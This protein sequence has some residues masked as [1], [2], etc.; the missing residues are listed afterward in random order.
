MEK[1][2]EQAKERVAE[3][4]AT[5]ARLE[6]EIARLA[7][8][9]ASAVFMAILRALVETVC[10]TQGQHFIVTNKIR[11]YRGVLAMLQGGR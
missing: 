9:D 11:F 3:Q 8:A 6:A 5:I 2:R 10:A 4:D 7:Q 1:E